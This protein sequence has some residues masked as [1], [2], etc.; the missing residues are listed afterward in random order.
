MENSNKRFEF[1][2]LY[3]K[4]LY[5][6]GVGKIFQVSEL[7]LAARGEIDEHVQICDEITYVVSGS[8]TFYING[9][10]V[11]LK[12]GQIC[13]LRKNS[14]H[15]I[16]VGMNRDFRYLCIGIVLNE[17]NEYTKSFISGMKNM[18]W[19]VKNDTG[20]M[21]IILEMFINEFYMPDRRTDAM[22]NLY[23]SIV[24]LM[25]TR[26]LEENSNEKHQNTVTVYAQH[27]IYNILRYIDR[28]Y[29]NIKSVDDIAK[30]F[31]YSEYY[32]SHLFRQKVGISIK[33]Y[34]ILKKMERAAELLK[35]TDISI[36]DISESMNYYS[37][38]TFSRAFKKIYSVTPTVYRKENGN[39]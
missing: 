12:H 24:F 10:A 9:E 22:I 34:V 13:Y 11:V 2:K 19:F 16:E 6:I 23:A 8:A 31:S 35:K 18:N 26:M 30:R 32:I 33:Q 4:E 20:N 36:T 21:R 1:N 5:E 28:E 15:K 7:S 17:Q 25:L 3:L 27:M 14:T 37:P 39:L 29:M 38:H